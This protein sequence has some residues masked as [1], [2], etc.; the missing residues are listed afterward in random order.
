CGDM[1][2]TTLVMTLPSSDIVILSLNC[3]PTTSTFEITTRTVPSHVAELLT[4]APLAW[5]VISLPSV[6][7]ARVVFWSPR[8]L[9]C[10]STIVSDGSACVTRR[11]IA[12]GGGTGPKSLLAGLN[13]HSPEKFGL[14]AADKVPVST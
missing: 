11:V 14:S 2:W 4:S 1:T 3:K 10:S 8:T 9:V 13:F 7:Y 6:V 5:N 12:V